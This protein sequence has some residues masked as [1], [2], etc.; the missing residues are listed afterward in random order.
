VPTPVLFSVEVIP[1]CV[2]I[3]ENRQFAYRI[4]EIVATIIQKEFHSSVWPSSLLLLGNG[5]HFLFLR[6]ILF[7]AVAGHAPDDAFLAIILS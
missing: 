1:E 3:G 7:T 4:L 2:V 5:G 6:F